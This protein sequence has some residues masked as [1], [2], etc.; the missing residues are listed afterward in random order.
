MGT[1]DEPPMSGI[2]PL[3]FD[4]FLVNIMVIYG[5]KQPLCTQW[6]HIFCLNLRHYCITP[7]RILHFYAMA[8]FLDRQGSNWGHCPEE[9]CSVGGLSPGKLGDFAS[10]L[11]G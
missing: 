8:L 7:Y 10:G 5:L 6:H 11:R 9:V 3:Q 1:P 4:F 2:F